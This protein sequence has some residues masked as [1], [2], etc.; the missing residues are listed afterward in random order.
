[1]V[2]KEDELVNWLVQ[3]HE[4]RMI[5]E[6][7]V[8]PEAHYNNYGTRGVVDLH[9]REIEHLRLGERHTDT[10][11]EVKSESAVR[12]ST[13]ANQIIRQF[14][15]MRENFYEDNRR[16]R[17]YKVD[18]ELTFELTP[19]VVEHV[20]ENISMYSAAIKKERYNHRNGGGSRLL[21]RF[22]DPGE[23][24]SPGFFRG[25]PNT[26]PTNVADWVRGLQVY[27]EGVERRNANTVLLAILED[28]YDFGLGPGL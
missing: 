9:A 19:Y 17:P 18:F 10:I 14:N 12:Q 5:D 4:R 6:V 3:S 25:I 2:S 8:E 28:L 24:S 16:T 13:G 7:E 21:F 15:R 11:Y 26:P 23:D 27:T 20:A 22:P 1:M